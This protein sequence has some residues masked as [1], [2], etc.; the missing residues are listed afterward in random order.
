[1]S[2]QDDTNQNTDNEGN[3]PNRWIDRHLWQIQPVR[4]VLVLLAIVGVFW[5]GYKLSVVTVPVLL[6]ITL[7]Y[8]FEPVIQWATKREWVSRQGAVAGVIGAC[9]LV[10]VVPIV[11]GLSFAAVQGVQL[12]G[13]VASSASA[14]KTAVDNPDDE[15]AQAHVEGRIPIWIRDQ[16]LEAKV[17]AAEE[18]KA[19]E[20]AAKAAAAAEAKRASPRL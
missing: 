17:R 18:A 10:V 1:M 11:L 2:Q 16:I 15:M 3:T 8:L 20:E 14:I 12:A 9:A 4:D 7:A 5:L 19:A 6:A 13:N